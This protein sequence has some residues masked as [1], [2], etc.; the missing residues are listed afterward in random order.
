MA[1]K[2]GKI[3]LT[4]RR[5][6]ELLRLNRT[7]VLEGADLRTLG[8]PAPLAAGFNE[9]LDK[10]GEGSFKF[11]ELPEGEERRHLRVAARPVVTP[12]KQEVIGTVVSLRDVT[13][14]RELDRMKEEFFHY[15]THDL[16]NPLSSALGFLDMLL[17]GGAGELTAEQG[18]IVTAVKR[19]ATRL[20]GMVN[21]ILDIAKMEAGKIKV[22]LQD[23]SMEE[24]ARRA[25]SELE[26]LA[27]RKSIAVDVSGPPEAVVRADPDMIERVF[28]NLLG[29][30]IKFTPEG[31][32]VKMS[33]EDLETSL[34]AAVE[35]SGEGIPADLLGRLFGKFEQA[36]RRK[37]G[38]TGLGLAIVKFFVES[39]LGKVWAES[40]PGRGARF[41]FEIPKNLVLDKSGRVARPQ[42][43]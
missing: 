39:H 23:V 1:D 10:P 25:R 36:E 6:L 22:N 21:N 17:R 8:M 33:V 27:A 42:A 35:D 43:S 12:E 29:N 5:A 18:S 41:L 40:E 37:K 14:E 2:E 13:A 7:S 4:N 3:L 24:A 16:R 28:V 11:V 15:V 38:G 20:L 9:V 26:T 32:R 34:R 31:G 30:A 19:S